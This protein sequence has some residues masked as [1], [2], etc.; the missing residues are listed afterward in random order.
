MKNTHLGKRIANARTSQGLSKK[1]LAQQLGVQVS[2]VKRWENGE[3]AP[4]ANRMD[5]LAGV[6]G[7]PL[8]WLMAGSDIP[9]VKSSPE[10][11]EKEGKLEK[12]EQLAVKLSNL[13]AEIRAL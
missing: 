10:I 6:L 9:P 5:Q 8:M 2:T 7:V 11:N 4:R 13:L 3:R 1:Q 12:A